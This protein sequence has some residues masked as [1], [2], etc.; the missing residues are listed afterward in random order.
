MLLASTC[1]ML[2]SSSVHLS[3]HIPG[4]Q[5]VGTWRYLDLRLRTRILHTKIHSLRYYV[6][7][8]HSKSALVV[9]DIASS[10]QGTGSKAAVAGSSTTSA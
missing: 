9:E 6:V 8:S 10:S 4:A 2:A 7:A 1:A 3:T 5:L